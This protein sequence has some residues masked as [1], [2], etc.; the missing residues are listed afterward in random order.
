M[1]SLR[2]ETEAECCADTRQC[3]GRV[4]RADNCQSPE[5]LSRCQI[6]QSGASQRHTRVTWP[7][8]CHEVLKS[9]LLVT[10]HCCEVWLKLSQ[11]VINL[12]R[13]MWQEE[14][15]IKLFLTSPQNG[16]ST[17]NSDDSVNAWAWHVTLITRY[18]RDGR[19]SGVIFIFMAPL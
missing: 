12:S 6:G 15:P 10:C 11:V 2:L 3:G 9:C 16:E 8:T 5:R 13:W 18:G 7:I 14:S 4:Q 1:Q 19:V 17:S